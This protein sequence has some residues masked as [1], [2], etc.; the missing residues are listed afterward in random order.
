MEPTPRQRAREVFAPTIFTRNDLHEIGLSGRRI[1]TAVR[2]GRL[3]RLRRDRYARPGLPAD[4]ER[5]VR[6]GGRLGCVSLLKMLGVFVR[7]ADRVHVHVARN[8][9][10]LRGDPDGSCRV[11]WEYA[12]ESEFAHATTLTEAIRQSVRCQDARSALATLDSLVHHRLVTR[13]ELESIFRDLPRRYQVLL[14]LVDPTAASGPETFVR[15]MLRTLGLL[16]ETQVEIR[17]V[18]IVDFVVDGWLIIE[19]DSKRFHE[20]WQKQKQDRHRD[21]AAARLGYVTVR[22]LAADILHRSE[23]VQA[24]VKDIVEMLGGGVRPVRRSQ[25]RKHRR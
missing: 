9:S 20:G 25:L 1:T 7:E 19:C 14:H 18:G 3:I 13:A 15:V 2:S 22:P 4:V 6:L 23:S 21:I 10:R 5:A 24:A 8:G 17:G 12:S 16:Y 11:H